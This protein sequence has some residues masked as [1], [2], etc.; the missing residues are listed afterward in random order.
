MK[1]YDIQ[2]DVYARFLIANGFCHHSERFCIINQ[3]R[4]QGLCLPQLKPY[5]EQNEWELINQIRNYCQL[6]QIEE[7]NGEGK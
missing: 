3:M 6:S 1:E 5:K 7:M 2:A 4:N